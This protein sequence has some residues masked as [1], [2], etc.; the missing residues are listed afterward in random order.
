M[1]Y[2]GSRYKDCK[3]EYDSE[4]ERVTFAIRTPYNFDKRNC[5]VHLM[6]EG[7]T[8]EQLAYKN[9]GDSQLWWVIMEANSKYN[10]EF[11]I[12]P[13]DTILIPTKQEVVRIYE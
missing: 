4:T 1:I 13:G 8:L 10:F 11:E 6:V 7:E 5:I 9:Y 3:A 12:Q 2:V